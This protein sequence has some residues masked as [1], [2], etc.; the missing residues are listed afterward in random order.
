M[1][2]ALDEIEDAET[3]DRVFAAM[4]GIDAVHREALH[5]LVRLFKEGVLEQVITDPAINSLMGMY[6]LLPPE[7][8]GCQ[9]VWDFVGE[10]IPNLATRDAGV[11]A[12]IPAEPPHWS[13]APPDALANEGTAYLCTLEEGNVLLLRLE[14]VDYALSG[15]CPDHSVSLENG[16][17]DGVMWHCPNGPGCSFD[18]RSGKKLG[19][20][21]ALECFPVRVEED[22]RRM[23][24]FG[25][26]FE[27]K[28]PAF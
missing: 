16:R 10:D 17:L 24:G 7:V 22:G 26:P 21:S 4:A 8:P 28:L 20:G 1:L 27:A 23:I 19:G 13:P 3:R 25:V 5:R 2:G 14:G 9:K 11:N 18:I 15:D 6:D 12:A